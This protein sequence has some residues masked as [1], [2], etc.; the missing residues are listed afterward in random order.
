MVNLYVHEDKSTNCLLFE[1]V[2]HC[3]IRLKIPVIFRVGGGASV[4][5]SNLIKGARFVSADVT[6]LFFVFA[7]K[8][9]NNSSHHLLLLQ[10]PMVELR[11]SSGVGCQGP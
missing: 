7:M 9:G 11:W 4:Y 2:G 3:T 6:Y 5:Q 1:F 10:D 8:Q